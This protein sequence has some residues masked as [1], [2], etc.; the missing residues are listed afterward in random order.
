MKI[1]KQAAVVVISAVLMGAASVSSWAAM[2]VGNMATWRH[3]EVITAANGPLSATGS[4]LE[5]SLAFQTVSQVRSK[6]K[7]SHIYGPDDVVGDPNTC[8][9]GGYAIPSAYAVGVTT[10]V[11]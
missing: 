10:G 6:C 5:P 9:M 8:I 11:R 1:V 7:A 3:A 2:P 4:S